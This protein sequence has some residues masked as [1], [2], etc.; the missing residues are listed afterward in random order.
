MASQILGCCDIII[1]F[2]KKEWQNNMISISPSP[3]PKTRTQFDAPR[4][5]HVHSSN[6]ALS[7]QQEMINMN[8][9]PPYYRRS[10]QECVY[11][12]SSLLQAGTCTDRPMMWHAILP[13]MPAPQHLKTCSTPI[14]SAPSCLSPSSIAAWADYGTPMF[15]HLEIPTTSRRILPR[16]IYERSR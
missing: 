11:L 12:R 1:S 10:I 6:S 14:A 5:T 16:Q 4:A 7:S 3:L 8:N 9:M 2:L 13:F 15:L